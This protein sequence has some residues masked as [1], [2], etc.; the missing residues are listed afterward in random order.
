[1]VAA[2]ENNLCPDSHQAGECP[3]EQLN[4]FRGGGGVIVHVSANEHSID[5]F[6]GYGGDQL[7]NEPLTHIMQRGAVERTA[8]MPVGGVQYFHAS[9][10]RTGSNR[11]A[12]C[13]VTRR[14]CLMRPF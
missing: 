2:A 7:I 12:S 6:F 11:Y 14:A 8:Q 13:T 1:M 10:Y 9:Q 4:G 3:V 5:V